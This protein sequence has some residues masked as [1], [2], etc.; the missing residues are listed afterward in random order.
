M[1]ILVWGGSGGRDG[2]T[3]T[4]VATAQLIRAG[5]LLWRELG[6]KP[7]LLEK[8]TPTFILYSAL[9][10]GMDRRGAQRLLSFNNVENIWWLY[11]SV[12]FQALMVIQ[13]R[14]KHANKQQDLFRTCVIWAMSTISGIWT[15]VF[16]T[17]P[18]GN[19]NSVPIFSLMKSD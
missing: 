7:D 9:I 16:C 8:Q 2:H 5:Q 12:V 1:S 11:N 19:W 17:G 10:Y 4:F 6:A 14:P 3:W 13:S 15:F 18:T